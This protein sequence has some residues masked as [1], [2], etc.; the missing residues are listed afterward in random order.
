MRIRSAAVAVLA[1]AT[2]ALTG[3]GGGGDDASSDAGAITGDITFQTWALTPKFT[4]Y[5]NQ[6]I[7]GFQAKYPGTKVQLLDQPGDGYSDKVLSQAASNTLPDVINLPP[8]YALPLAKQGLLTDVSKGAGVDL[9]ATYVPG[10]ID[11]YKF[12]D[13]A[14]PNAVYGYPWYLN[15]DLD[16]WNTKQFKACGLDAATPPA[17]T[18]ELFAA[19][20]TMHAKCPDDFLMSRKPDVSDFVRAGIPIFSQDG[21][22]FAFN[23]DQAVALVDKYRDAYQKGLMPSSVLNSDYQ[24]N[25]KLFTQGKVAWTTGGGTGLADFQKDNPSLKGNVAVSNALDTPPLYVQGVSVSAKSK[26]VATATAFAEWVTNADNQN[27]FGHLVNVFPSTTASSADPY[28][29]KDDGT[30]EAHARVLAFN[31]L[32]TAKN[33]I[34]YEVNKDMQTVLDQQIAL[35]LKGSATSKQALDDAVS[36]LNQMLERQK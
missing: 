15:T 16:Y 17:T 1:T 2:L 7:A 35:A 18:D 32:K 8:D 19:A 3:C 11:A 4:D 9:A 36:K 12:K 34:P 26:H 21:K 20:A 14:D 31:E 33:L 28:F 24:G 22:Q 23:T 29:A 27:K 30:D 25:S 13:A 5:L 6:V 10:G